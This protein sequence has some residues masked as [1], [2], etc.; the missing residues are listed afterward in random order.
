MS[1][2]SASTPTAMAVA[3]AVA[4]AVQTCLDPARANEQARSNTVRAG[5][6]VKARPQSVFVS[7]VVG[8]VTCPRNVT[9]NLGPTSYRHQQ[10][11]RK[12]KQRDGKV[13]LIED[14]PEQHQQPQQRT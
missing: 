5:R 6:K 11:Q 10:Q 9:P 7:S 13:P 4:I 12:A 8:W 1:T 3:M 2:Q 14:D